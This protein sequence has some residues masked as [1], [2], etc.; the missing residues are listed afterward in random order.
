MVKVGAGD[1][2]LMRDDLHPWVSCK[3]AGGDLEGGY[4]VCCV[5]SSC[6]LHIE[7]RV[8]TPAFT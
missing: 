8:Q 5:L 7:V 3:P 2:W 4:L 1:E 6:G